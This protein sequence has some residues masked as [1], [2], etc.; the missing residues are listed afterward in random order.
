[1]KLDTGIITR[2]LSRSVLQTK[3]NSPH[4]FFSLGVIGTITS[5]VLACRATLK[6][7][8]VLDEIK[9]DFETV[10]DMHSRIDKDKYNH[11]EYIKDLAYVYGKSVI[12]LIQL[13]GPATAVGGVSIASLAGSHVQLT[14]RNAALSITLAAVT[15]AYNEYREVVRK[16]VGEEREFEL[17]HDIH[18]KEI[19]VAGKKTTAKY[20]GN[21]YSIYARFFDETCVNWQ[22]DPE[23]NRMFLQHQERYANDMLKARGH[24]LLNDVYDALGMERS[25]A[26]AVVGWVLNG[27]G[28]GYIDFGIFELSSNRFV[29]GL[30]RSIL[31]DFNVDGVVFELIGE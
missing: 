4:I 23:I 26:G 21:S 16:E 7:E 11:Q 22:K 31:L 20:S 9:N 2:S 19:E 18:T 17:F 1:M 29:N 25:S 30:E 6:L 15:K 24:V 3:A 13:Y 28:D 27:D 10:K 8:K 14:R 5:T 12:K